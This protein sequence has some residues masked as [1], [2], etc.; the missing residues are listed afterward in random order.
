MSHL[1]FGER[2]N[3]LLDAHDA[4]RV[5]SALHTHPPS[6]LQ[7]HT[8]IYMSKLPLVRASV[9]QVSVFDTR[10]PSPDSVTCWTEQLSR[11]VL[12]GRIEQGTKA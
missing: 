10:C 5:T 3:F 9:L 12:P 8:Y 7:H 6:P 1:T 4:N 11:K 2:V